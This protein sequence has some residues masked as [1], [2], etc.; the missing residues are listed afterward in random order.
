MIYIHV[1]YLL[2]T[3]VVSVA[4][5]LQDH[6]GAALSLLVGSFL[7]WAG[8]VGARGSFDGT[9]NQKLAGLTLGLVVL[10]L[11]ALIANWGHAT[12]WLWIDRLPAGIWVFVGTVIG[13]I[14]T[15]QKH[16]RL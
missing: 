15:R 10:G 3:I 4:I 11:G 16:A 6:A 1:A 9:W 14:F 8:G 12:V 7:G 5:L 13:F 2:I